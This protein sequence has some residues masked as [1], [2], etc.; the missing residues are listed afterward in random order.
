M[1]LCIVTFP[2][3]YF[4]LLIIADQ[5]AHLGDN[6]GIL[7]VQLFNFVN[8]HLSPAMGFHNHMKQSITALHKSQDLLCNKIINE[9]TI[10]LLIRCK[11]LWLWSGAGFIWAIPCQLPSHCKQSSSVTFTRMVILFTNKT[12]QRG[13]KELKITPEI[14]F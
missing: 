11:N 4:I 5:E 6:N 2:S 12:F 8:K 9:N 1:L 14:V 3:Q 7:S 13:I 10:G